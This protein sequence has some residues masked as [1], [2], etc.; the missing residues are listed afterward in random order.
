MKVPKSA[1]GVVVTRRAKLR[2]HGVVKLRLAC[3]KELD[4]TGSIVLRTAKPVK[5]PH[6]PKHILKLGKGRF[7]KVPAGATKKVKVKLSRS[8]R[9][10]LL[11]RG[12]LKSKATAS[13][14]NPSGKLRRRT[15]RVRLRR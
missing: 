5:L 3:V 15:T 12:R 10:L 4:C 8:A 6:R 1:V 7:K 13:V 9:R 11:A 14:R 2:R